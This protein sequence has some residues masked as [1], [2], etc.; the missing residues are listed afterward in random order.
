MRVPLFFVK[1]VIDN[2]TNKPVEIIP[3]NGGES[4]D[5]YKHY[6]GN[7]KYSFMKVPAYNNIVSDYTFTVEDYTKNTD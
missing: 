5:V 2:E 7:E 3:A 1:V 4:E 6:F